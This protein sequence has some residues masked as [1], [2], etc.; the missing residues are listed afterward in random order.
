MEEPLIS[1]IVPIYKVEPYL[2]KCIDSLI[3]QTYR[4]I[5]IILVDDGSPDSCPQIC[6]DYR[7]KYHNV[8]VVHKE[9]GGLVSARKAGILASCGDYI[10]HV[11]G[12]DFVETTHFEI[13]KKSIEKNNADIVMTDYSTIVNNS[14]EV[15]EQPIKFDY[16]TNDGIKS[17]A[18]TMMSVTPFFTFGIFPSI[19]TKC[20]R[21]ELAL[22]YQLSIPDTIVMGED[23]AFTFP[24]L[25][26]ATSVCHIKENGYIYR[27]NPSS[28][29]NSYDSKLQIKVIALFDYLCKY[30]D[31]SSAQFLDYINFLSIRVLSN[32]IIGNG[33]IKASI[34]KLEDYLSYD[35]VRIASETGKMPFKDKVL[36]YCVKKRIYPVLKMIKYHWVK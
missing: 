6:D 9:N 34:M 21:R 5:E 27:I 29:T 18:E 13:I 14:K 3:N 35:L 16:I 17:I 26:E 1:V 25:L 10:S 2:K 23:A 32:E 33:D 22:K 15:Y 30:F 28:I 4:N 7:E 11:D 20:V 24:C 8:K 36:F 19:W 31:K 12:D